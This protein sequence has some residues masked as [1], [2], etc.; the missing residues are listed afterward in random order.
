MVDFMTAH[1]NDIAHDLVADGVIDDVETQAIIERFLE[2]GAIDQEEAEF[3]FQINEITSGHPDN[4]TDFGDFF[5]EALTAFVLQDDM[6]PGVLDEYEWNWLKEMIG[7]DDEL[8]D[9]EMRLLMNIAEEAVSVPASLDDFAKS[10]E[11]M[12]YEDEGE[13]TLFYS[14]KKNNSCLK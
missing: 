9:L 10:F 6:S 8:D 1:L 14:R 4:S 3:L 7:D 13:N 5:V 12:E 11:E 2:D